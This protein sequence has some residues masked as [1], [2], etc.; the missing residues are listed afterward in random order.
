MDPMKPSLHPVVAQVTQRIV[1]RS[2]LH[3]APDA[4]RDSARRPMR[5]T[6]AGGRLRTVRPTRWAC[7]PRR[8]ITARGTGQRGP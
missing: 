2:R 5:Y 7:R 1:A 3:Q 6:A 8:S 4:Q